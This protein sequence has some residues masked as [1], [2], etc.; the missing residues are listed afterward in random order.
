MLIN[1][2]IEKLD[3]LLYDF[4]TI[5]GITISAW[6]ADF[7]Q[8]SY[9]P[10]E[11]CAFCHAVKSKEKGKR[12]CFLSDRKLCIECSKTE[13]PAKHTCHAGLI[14]M[15]FPIKYKDDILGYIMFGQIADKSEEEMLPAIIQLGET[16]GLSPEYLTDAY[17]LLPK[18]DQKR[19]DSAANILKQA[20]R[21]LWL[22]DYIGIGYDTSASKIDEYL[23]LHLGDQI[24]IN[25]LCRELN[26]PKKRLY[27]VAH[28]NFG[29]PIGEYIVSLRI[30][31]AKRL[32]ESTDLPIQ[33]VAAAVG[34]HDYNY[35][36]KF[37]KL[38][39]GISPLKYRKGFPFNLHGSIGS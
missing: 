14:D 24:T 29:V 31:E 9:Q 30:S 12:A 11:M 13:R 38:R 5:T 37:F 39:V 27:A 10:R 1:F 17:R 36:A 20:T 22:S 34:I 8:I 15:A 19:I 23:R 7:H 26:M 32:L 18:Y 35:F 4:Y 25:S 33:Q 6:T 16:L 2:N 28:R 3:K 21:Y